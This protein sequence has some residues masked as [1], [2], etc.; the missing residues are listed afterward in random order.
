MPVLTVRISDAEKASLTRRAK[1]SG[2]SAAALV[3]QFL[4]EQPI[5]TAEDLLRQMEKHMGNK[6]LRSRTAR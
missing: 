1:K 2:M 3:R 4:N 6:S 5:E